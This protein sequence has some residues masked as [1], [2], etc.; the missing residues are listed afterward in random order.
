M[1]SKLGRKGDPRMHKA[2]AARLANPSL[3]LYEALCIGGFDYCENDD[4]SVTDEKKVTLGQRKNQLSRRL[5]LARKQGAEDNKVSGAQSPN[6]D[7]TLMGNNTRGRGGE[8]GIAISKKQRTEQKHLTEE[9]LIALRNE[10]GAS[11]SNKSNGRNGEAMGAPLQMGAHQQK[12]LRFTKCL[13]STTFDR[14]CTM[15]PAN[16]YLQNGW[17]VNNMPHM[18]GGGNSNT[19]MGPDSLAGSAQG[20]HYPPSQF[21]APQISNRIPDQN[22][23]RY[24]HGGSAVALSS[25]TATAQ[26]VGLSLDQ[27]ALTL[28]SNTSSL[29]KLVAEVRSGDSE[30][31][32]EQMALDLYRSDVKGLYTKCLLLA[33]VDATLTDQNTPTYIKFALKAWEVEGKRLRNLQDKLKGGKGTKNVTIDIYPRNMDGT[34]VSRP[35]GKDD[36]NNDAAIVSSDSDG[37]NENHNN[38]HCSHNH[39]HNHGENNGQNGVH[40]GSTLKHDKAKCDARH[41]HRLGECGHRAIIHQPKDGSPHIDF[42]V[43]DHVECYGGQD[44]LSLAG[45][46]F[47]TAW[48]SKYKCKDLE[49]PCA[50]ACGKSVASEHSSNWANMDLGQEPKLFKLSEIDTGDSEWAFDANEESDGGVMGLFKLGRESSA[51]TADN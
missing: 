29:S 33:G 24:H 49:E 41:M 51:E 38:E 12:R 48:P 32:Q 42:I 8:N 40:D 35:I 28:T 31:K 3:S 10:L 1:S 44:S 5:R 45:K 20:V 30:I 46:S 2:V 27:L 23:Q 22:M 4:K 7:T 14:T 18:G 43:N 11:S 25:L 19:M 26:S 17:P 39:G 9:Q 15:A 37:H 34:L 36:E 50:K 21:F 6:A 16:L 47:D 13:N